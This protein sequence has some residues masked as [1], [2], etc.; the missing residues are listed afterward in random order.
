M[1][2][3]YN[4]KTFSEPEKGIL[5]FLF[6]LFPH[7]KWLETYILNTFSL[8]KFL[9]KYVI[10]FYN[11]SIVST[12]SGYYVLLWYSIL[13]KW[14]KLFYLKKLH[15]HFWWGFFIFSPKSWS[16]KNFSYIRFKDSWIIEFFRIFSIFNV[17]CTALSILT[18][19][20][21]LYTLLIQT[22]SNKTIY[23]LTNNFK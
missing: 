3:H 20:C 15:L 10:N 17:S 23:V 4:L 11:L 2:S 7:A 6:L 8:E 1:Y 22:I 16:W 13:E 18:I 9:E 5:Q 21:S 12:T 14:F 19:D